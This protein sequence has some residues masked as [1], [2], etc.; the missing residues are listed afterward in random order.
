M[1]RFERLISL[2]CLGLFAVPA[3]AQDV[4]ENIPE[5]AQAVVESMTRDPGIVAMAVRDLYR[6]IMPGLMTGMLGSIYWWQL[7]YLALVAAVAWAVGRAVHEIMQRW[8]FK[9][10][11]QIQLPLS[12]ALF[13]ALRKPLVMMITFG[14]L[15]WG[16]IDAGL[17]PGAEGK[18]LFVAQALLAIAAVAFAYRTVD[19]FEGL[20]REWAGKTEG[21]LDDQLVPMVGR[22]LKVAVVALGI[23]F[24]LQNQGVEVAS[25]LA[26]LGIGGIAF[27][28]AAKDTVENLFGSLTIFLDRPFQ[29]GDWIVVDDKWE[30]VVEEV[31]LRSTRIRSFGKSMISVP[32]AKVGNS[33]I[34]NMGQ[35][36]FRRQ[37]TTIGVEYSTP[38]AKLETL[39]ER[40]NAIVM[41]HPETWKGTCEIH[42][43][44]FGASSLDIMVY[45]FIEAPDWHRELQVR[46]GIFIAFMKAAE[47]LGINFAFPSTSLYVEKMPPGFGPN[48][49]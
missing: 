11:K 1:S 34:N 15:Y 37:T 45:F 14:V 44:D 41:E 8:V 25:L 35:R 22:V 27:A 17:P 18:L 43:K 23:V 39:V 28:L 9:L 48:Q 2:F 40:M 31:G 12:Q 42:F 38:T 7:L 47:E 49:A 19:V 36:P 16:V 20:A 30:G 6:A 29:I 13:R 24:V 33:P 46:Q 32:N 10:A 3:W 4:A 21:K 26:G 5:P